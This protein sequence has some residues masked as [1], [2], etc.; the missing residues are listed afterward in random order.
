MGRT[1]QFL[2]LSLLSIL[3]RSQKIAVATEVIQRIAQLEPPG[4]F[5]HVYKG[6]SITVL[7]E[8]TVLSFLCRAFQEDNPA[9]LFNDTVDTR[10]NNVDVSADAPV[11]STETTTTVK[12]APKGRT[13]YEGPESAEERD[14]AAAKVRSVLPGQKFQASVTLK[15]PPHQVVRRRII[16][17]PADGDATY[18]AMQMMNDMDGVQPVVLQAHDVLFGKGS[19]CKQHPGNKIFRTFVRQNKKPYEFASK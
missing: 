16:A 18:S 7:D 17:P 2:T 19:S 14:R 15:A 4:R 1:F 9:D 8:P 3:C 13:I 11:V 12:K 6:G 10:R 5:V